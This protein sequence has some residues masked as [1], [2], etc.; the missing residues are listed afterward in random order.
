MQVHEAQPDL[1]PAGPSRPADTAR[2]KKASRV[3]HRL[4][5]GCGEDHSRVKIGLVP[6]PGR[7][8]GQ[9][10]KSPV[11]DAGGRFHRWKAPRV[12]RISCLFAEARVMRP[13]AWRLGG[14]SEPGSGGNP[15]LNAPSGVPMRKRGTR[16][17]GL[18]GSPGMRHASGSARSSLRGGGSRVVGSSKARLPDR[19]R[20]WQ[21]RSL[22]P[23]V[24]RSHDERCP[25]GSGWGRGVSQSPARANAHGPSS[26]VAARG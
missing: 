14:N 23:A 26:R 4:A 20:T 24:Q 11:R 6:T 16:S 8:D 10:R 19:S 1:L 21:R 22:Q 7:P 2:L 17:G 5:T 12:Q 15:G 3:F 18:S 13:L 9:A 25:S